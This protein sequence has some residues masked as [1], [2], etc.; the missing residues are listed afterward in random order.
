MAFTPGTTLGLAGE[1]VASLATARGLLLQIAAHHGPAEV[2]IVLVAAR[3][4]AAQWDWIKW[5]PHVRPS[6]FAEG[7]LLVV[8]ADEAGV[9]DGAALDD[10]VADAESGADLVVVI[11]TA[12]LADAGD[13]AIRRLLRRD[14]SPVSGLVLAPTVDGLPDLCDVVTDHH[15]AIG[16]ATA[17]WPREGGRSVEIVIGGLPDAIAERS[18][19]ALARFTDPDAGG[20][21]AALPARVG[22]A[23]ILGLHGAEA[24]DV[25]ARWAGAGPLTAVVGLSETG[26][27]AI[28]LDAG[29]PHL[30]VVGGRGA[31]KTEHLLGIVTS[32][33]A[34]QPPERV[35]FVLWGESFGHLHRL[36]HVASVVNRV[37][38]NAATIV[39]DGLDPP[40][41]ALA[42]AWYRREVAGVHL[43]RL[44]EGML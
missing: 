41:D 16:E 31:G 9:V 35:H 6:S 40:T 26:P 43:R 17:R 24:T 30:V 29:G 27:L 10:V 44:L 2:R 8:T 28:N 36:P 13:F 11:D 37:D 39:T 20:G 38:D 3:A 12:G 32:I 23:Q 5:L 34:S 4:T 19:R 25:Q 33:A 7:R 15:E 22:Q 14:R 1:R 18:A 42:S 21:S